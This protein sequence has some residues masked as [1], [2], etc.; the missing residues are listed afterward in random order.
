MG[1]LLYSDLKRILKDKLLLVIALITALLAVIRPILSWALLHNMDKEIA[2]T[3]LNGKT[4]FFSAFHLGDTLSLVVTILFAV[5]L[6]KD[7]SHGTI[8]NKIVA[9]YTR[10]AIFFSTFLAG[11][12]AIFTVML[13]FALLTLGVSLTLFPY[14]QDPFGWKDLWYLLGSVGLEANL[15]LFV[16]ALVAWISTGSKGTGSVVLK[17]MCVN[18][19]ISFGSEILTQ[20]IQTLELQGNQASSLKVLRLIRNFDVFHH[21]SMIGSGTTYETKTLVYMIA[22]PLALTAITLFL[23]EW[24]FRKSDVK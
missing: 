19:V 8:R 15:Y 20:A 12:I 21:A 23:G 6:F 24:R 17:Y 13:L 5:I 14:Q 9:G 10:T 22:V 11:L 18:A 3:V 2:S 16:A 7:F 4:Y 1:N